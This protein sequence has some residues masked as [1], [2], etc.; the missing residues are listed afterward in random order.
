MQHRINIVVNILKYDKDTFIKTQPFRGNGKQLRGLGIENLYLITM[1][2]SVNVVEKIIK[3][4]WP[5][6]IL[7]EEATNTDNRSEL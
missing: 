6:T 7:M 5:S 1:V 3:N 4:S 2:G